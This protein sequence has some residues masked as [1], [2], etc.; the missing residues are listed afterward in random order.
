M[1]VSLTSFKQR[2]DEL[3]D[4]S[5]VRSKLLAIVASALL[6]THLTMEITDAWE[7]PSEYSLIAKGLTG[8]LVVFFV[9]VSLSYARNRF[10]TPN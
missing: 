3:S 2:W 5:S 4:Y 7:L 9:F 1:T 8:C 10:F 6:G